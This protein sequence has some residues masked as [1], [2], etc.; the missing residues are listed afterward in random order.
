MSR[1]ASGTYT[2]PSGNP[3]VTGTIISSTWANT[4]MDDIA[5]ELSDSLSRSGKGGMTAVLEVVDG[6]VSLPGLAFTSDPNTGMYRP[7]DDEIN[8]AI[9]G[10]D[11]LALTALGLEVYHASADDPEIAFHADDNTLLSRIKHT[12]ASELKILSLEHGLPVHISGEDT[13]GTEQVIFAG[14]PDGASVLYYA[15]SIVAS[16]AADGLEVRDTSGSAPILSMQSDAGADLAFL[17]VVAS[18]GLRLKHD[19]NGEQVWIEI[20]DTGGTD[21]VMMAADP[22]AGVNFNYTGTVA[23]GTQA[24]GLYS[25]TLSGN[26]TF[27]LN[28]SA[29]TR[30]ALLTVTDS[31]S[32][33]IVRNDTDSGIMSLEAKD[34]GSANTK[35]FR[36]D[37]DGAVLLYYDGTSVFGTIDH[38]AVGNTSAAELKHADGS[39]YDLG[40]NVAPLVG[41]AATFSL[42][43]D[44]VGCLIR[45]TGGT[46]VD[47]D[48]TTNT[49]PVGSMWIVANASGSA[50]TVDANTGVT[51]TWMDGAGGANGDRT[52]A[53]GGVASIYKRASNA[54][55]IWGT[56]IS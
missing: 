6:T 56:G 16:T 41:A 54:Y 37:P 51:L 24:N 3:V 7:T 20:K 17:E 46:Q 53:N 44:Q 23:G 31:G 10:D 27:D 9:G 39:N 8:F 55:Y 5:D 38:T 28:N 26:S 36:G 14:D 42:D 52:L 15:G 22:D 35:V 1:D 32:E 34:S 43:R 30:L 25:Q 29:G 19:V 18:T 13:G 2:L 11:V 33:F 4:T 21:R 48:S 50:I 45:M 47:L 12:G 40:F 49:A